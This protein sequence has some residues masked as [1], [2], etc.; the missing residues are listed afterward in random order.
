MNVLKP[1]CIVGIAS[2]LFVKIISEPP[3]ITI[4][5]IEVKNPQSWLAFC[6][7]LTLCVYVHHNNNKQITI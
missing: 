4:H 6:G 3:S 1:L 2:V 5:K 7:M